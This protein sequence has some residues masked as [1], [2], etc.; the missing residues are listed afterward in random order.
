MTREDLIE[1]LRV[2]YET[3]SCVEHGEEADLNLA[4]SHV[5]AA[6]DGAEGGSQ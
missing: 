5:L 1:A 6:I 2:A 3:L 4:I